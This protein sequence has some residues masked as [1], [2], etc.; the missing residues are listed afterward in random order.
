VAIPFVYGSWQ[1]FRQ[2]TKRHPGCPVSTSEQ[3]LLLWFNAESIVFIYIGSPINPHIVILFF[4][5]FAIVVL[6]FLKFENNGCGL[7]NI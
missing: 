5:F 4:T 7:K 6:K 2:I 3:P 1:V